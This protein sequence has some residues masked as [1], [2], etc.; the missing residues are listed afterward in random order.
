MIYSKL[1]R[2]E[3]EEEE[4]SDIVATYRGISEDKKGM[5]EIAIFASRYS[6]EVKEGDCYITHFNA[7]EA[8]KIPIGEAWNYANKL[9]E[10]RREAWRKKQKE[11]STKK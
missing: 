3:Y 9:E 5:C 2:I 8:D 7:Y 10:E 11:K 4:S 6:D 1:R